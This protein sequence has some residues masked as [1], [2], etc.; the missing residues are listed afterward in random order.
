[1]LAFHGIFGAYGF[2]LS[3]DPRGSWSDFVHADELYRHA[4]PATK[5][6][7]RHSL[8]H[9]AHD[10]RQR[11]AAKQHLKH[12][13]VRLT[14]RQARA[15]AQGIANVVRASGYTLHALAVMPDHAHAVVAGHHPHDAGRILG[16]LKRGATEQLIAQGLH[17]FQQSA[18]TVA[19]S[20]WADRAWKVFLDTPPDVERA[21]RYVERNPTDA[22]LKPQRWSC[23]TPYSRPG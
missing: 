15:A 7:A 16:H 23:V 6:N 22:G 19:R 8:A 5:T 11:R 1:M 9:R 21:I 12:P 18:S 13:P 17:P 3:N 14:G 4:G 10:P 20:C 2:W